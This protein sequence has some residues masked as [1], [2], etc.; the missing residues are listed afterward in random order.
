MISKSQNKLIIILFIIA[1]ILIII[2]VFKVKSY[3]ID[4]EISNYNVEETYNKDEK[5]YSFSIKKDDIIYNYMVFSNYLR[6]KEKITSID[7]ISKD[8]YTCVIPK[9]SNLTSIPLCK[10]NNKDIDFRLIEDLKNQIDSSYYLTNDNISQKDNLT[11]YNVLDNYLLWNYKSFYKITSNNI[12]EISLFDKDVYDIS[13]ASIINNYLLIPNYDMG[14]N[15]NEFIIYNLD[16]N[17]KENWKIKYD[18]SMDS[19]ILGTYDKSIYLVDRKNKVEYEIVP[20]KKKI[21]IVG[22]ADKLGTIYENGWKNITINKLINENYKFTYDNIYEYKI[23]DNILYR[24]N[25]KNNQLLQISLQK[26]MKIISSSDD[27]VYYLIE[28]TLFCYN[29]KY[30]EQKIITNFEWNF[31]NENMIFIY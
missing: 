3:T 28:D 26:N 5:Y 23:I 21:R 9:I 31:N 25:K 12:E 8:N 6:G 30:G 17:E 4:Y 14:Y 11:I 10:L 16:N 7:T 18:I 13:L 24:L 1:T 15:Y 27:H 2:N 20:H 22:N 29:E 19:Y